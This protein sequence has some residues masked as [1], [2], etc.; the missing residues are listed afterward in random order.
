[1]KVIL[2]ADVEGKGLAGDVLDVAQGF[3]VNYLFPRKLAVQATKGELK[4]LEDRRVKLEKLEGERLAGA[5]ALKEKLE[6]EAVQLE[7]RA[8]EEGKLYGS[9]TSA[10]IA[11]AVSIQLELAIDKRGVE[12]DEPIKSAGEHKVPVRVYPG[13]VAELT[14]EVVAIDE[15]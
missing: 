4:Q 11:E 12:L 14:V 2:T 3:A 5:E 10:Q 13:V 6:A 9:V 8:G 7:M 15:G 1:M